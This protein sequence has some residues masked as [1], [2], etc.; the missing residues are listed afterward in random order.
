MVEVVIGRMAVDASTR[1]YVVILQEKDGERVLPIWIGQAEAESIIIEMHE[2]ARPRP[3]TH[4]L[5]RNLIAA[6]GA[7]LARVEITRVE[8]RT[9]FAEMHLVRG[10]ERLTVDARP[11]DSIAIALRFGAPMFADDALLTDSGE[12]WEPGAPPPS[13]EPP[14]RSAE[15]LKAYL[16]RLRPEDFGKFNP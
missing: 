13:A 3:L 14:E 8:E 2:I 5:C 4:D 11:S 9:Y 16:E 6:L 12:D 1:A 15:R 7:E 10:D